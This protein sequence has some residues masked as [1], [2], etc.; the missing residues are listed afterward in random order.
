[1]LGNNIENKILKPD[2]KNEF[3][4]FKI[5]KEILRKKLFQKTKTMVLY[6]KN[7]SL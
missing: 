7:L 3:D 4:Y 2:I 5:I 1:M 6:L